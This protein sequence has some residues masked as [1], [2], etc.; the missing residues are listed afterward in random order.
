MLME[1]PIFSPLTPNFFSYRRAISFVI[2]RLFST[3]ISASLAMT[4]SVSSSL[5]TE[6][7][8][9]PVA[10]SSRRRNAM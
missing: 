3:I 7:S 10:R 2:V 9:Y 4:E 6:D 1:S 8:A 5:A